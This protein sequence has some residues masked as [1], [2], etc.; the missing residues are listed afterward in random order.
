MMTRGNSVCTPEECWEGLKLQPDTSPPHSGQ[1]DGRPLVSL[2][3][4]PC[5]VSF[6]KLI[7]HVMARQ[8][9]GELVGR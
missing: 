8:A 7:P 1:V 2:Q 5:Q 6:A 9:K 3:A 4:T